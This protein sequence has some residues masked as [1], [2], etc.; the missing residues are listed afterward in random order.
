MSNRTFYFH[1]DIYYTIFKEY[2]MSPNAQVL[3]TC[4][5]GQQIKLSASY[6]RP[7]L[8]HEG[9]IGKFKITLDKNNKI[10]DLKKIK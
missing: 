5:G 1:I 3:V 10:T 6:F 4:E 9:V 8:T 2:Y 7:Y